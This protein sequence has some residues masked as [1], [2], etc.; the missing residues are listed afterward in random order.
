VSFSSGPSDSEDDDLEGYTQAQKR[1]HAKKLWKLMIN[2]SV[3]AH[4]TVKM[5]VLSINFTATKKFQ[6][7]S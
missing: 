2:L 7:I 5:Y 1:A 4:K 3:M 6:K